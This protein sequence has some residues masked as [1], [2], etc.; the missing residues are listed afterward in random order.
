MDDFRFEDLRVQIYPQSGANGKVTLAVDYAAADNEVANII[1]KRSV[2][3]SDSGGAQ[4]P[5]AVA[6]GAND[7]CSMSN[8]IFGRLT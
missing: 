7:K 1:D 6:I 2:K 4:P 3:R 8:C 5:I